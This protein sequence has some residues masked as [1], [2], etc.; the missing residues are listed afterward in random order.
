MCLIYRHLNVKYNLISKIFLQS[1]VY[2]FYEYQDS[3]KA[4]NIVYLTP[5]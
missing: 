4:E 5:A 2:L 3:F 1:S